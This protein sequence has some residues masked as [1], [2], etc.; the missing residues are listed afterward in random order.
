MK[1]IELSKFTPSGKDSH[2]SYYS[3]SQ[4]FAIYFVYPQN[5]ENVIVKGMS[6]E[7]RDYVLKHY[8]MALFRYTYWQKGEHRGDWCFSGR[9][10]YVNWDKKKRKYKFIFFSGPKSKVFYLK[11]MPHRW[12]PEFNELIG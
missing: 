6:R 12:I 2:A 4:P 1:I 5:G 7:V 10:R 11:R 3:Q 8:P 9:G